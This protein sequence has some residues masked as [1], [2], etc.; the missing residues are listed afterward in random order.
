MRIKKNIKNQNRILP[1]VLYAGREPVMAPAKEKKKAPCL[2][3]GKECTGSQYSVQCTICSLWCHK[4]CAAMSDA[5][6]KNLELQKKEMG[7]AFWACRSCLS[8]ANKMSTQIKEVDRKVERLKEKLEENTEGVK[9]AND[10]IETVQKTVGKVERKV[11]E[12]ERRME[13][14][15]MEEMRAREAIKR[16]V[17]VHGAVEPDYRIKTDRER[18]WRRIW[19]SAIE[20]SALQERR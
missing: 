7:Q 3:C 1:P 9:K 5:F 16:K 18:E 10:K 14:N 11:E 6:Y 20:S 4:D 13:E 8:F 12:V 2:G 15:M 17:I 19:R